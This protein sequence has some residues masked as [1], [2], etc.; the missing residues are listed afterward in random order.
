[1]NLRETLVTPTSGK[2]YRYK[3]AKYWIYTRNS[4]DTYHCRVKLPLEPPVRRSLKTSDETYAIGLAME[5]AVGLI[6][7]R[8]RGEALNPRSFSAV[9]ENYSQFLSRE[10]GRGE[11]SKGTEESSNRYIRSFFIPFFKNIRIDQIRRKQLA[12]YRE[13]RLDYYLGASSKV[14]YVRNGKKVVAKRPPLRP[15]SPNTLR[16]EYSALRQIFSFAR[17][18]GDISTLQLPVIKSPKSDKKR[19]P[20]FTPKQWKHLIQV[21]KNRSHTKTLWS[22]LSAKQMENGIIGINKHQLRQRK[23]LLEYILIMGNSGMRTMEAANLKWKDIDDFTARS[24]KEFPRL[25]VYG[26]GKRRQLVANPSVKRYLG[27]IK[28]RQEKYSQEHNFEFNGYDEHVFS[29][30]YGTQIKSFRNGFNA[31]L[32]EANLRTNTLGEKRSPYSLRHTYATFRIMYGHVD[33]YELAINMGTS[34]EMIERYYGHVRNEDI[35]DNLTKG[36]FY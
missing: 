10:V 30:E 26:K 21:A 25:S 36:S 8:N 6:E 2:F 1:M 32:I 3:D 28:D 24:G 11:C 27:R 5:L 34:V 20:S 13:W 23:L 7:K 12:E 4:S 14:T 22:E 29:D 17:E 35:A 31:L 19:R 15:P 33:V 18:R 9:A 16:R